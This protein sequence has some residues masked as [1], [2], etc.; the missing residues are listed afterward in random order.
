MNSSAKDVKEGFKNIQFDNMQEM[1]TSYH[2]L[3]TRV[4]DL[5]APLKTKQIMVVPNA[6]WFDFEYRELRRLCRKAEK[7]Y[8]KTGLEVHK[9]EFVDLRKQT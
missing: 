3:I 7:R 1:I 5:H 2:A 8:R 4:A 9:K 6:P